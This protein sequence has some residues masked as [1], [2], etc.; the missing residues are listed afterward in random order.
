M[1]IIIVD[2]PG[3]PNWDNQVQVNTALS[4]LTPKEQ[5]LKDLADLRYQKEVA[6]IVLNDI[7][8]KTD[9]E[10]QALITGAYSYS[11]INPDALIDWKASDNT[12]V[13]ITAETIKAIAQAVAEHVQACFSNEKVLAEQIIAAEEDELEAIDLNVGWPEYSE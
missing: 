13:Q 7:Q 6:G 2:G 11:M 4:V 5:K 1:E 12:W 8:I 9:R 10:S 3:S